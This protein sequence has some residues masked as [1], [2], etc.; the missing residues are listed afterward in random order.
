MEPDSYAELLLFVALA[1]LLGL[2][3]TIRYAL[4]SLSRARYQRLLDQ[5]ARV[6][7]IEHFFDHTS[8]YLTAAEMARGS[9]FIAVAV[10]GA[11]LVE[12][13]Q[14]AWIALLVAVVAVALTLVAGYAA[15][16]AV[17]VHEPERTAS[18][19]QWA[20]AALV[21]VFRP[22]VHVLTW[23]TRLLSRLFGHPNVPEGPMLTPEELR[24]NLAA[25]EEGGLIAEDERDMIDGIFDLEETTVWQIMV[26]RMDMVALPRTATIG[27]AV[28]LIVAGGFSRVPIYGESID[29]VIGILY[30]KDLLTLL[31]S[32]RLSDEV[33]QFVRPVFLVPESKRVDELLHE[34]QQRKT[35]IAIVID[36]YG[37]TAGLVTIEDL[38]EEIVGEIRD[39]FDREEDKIVKTEEGK[40]T[41]APAVSIDDV[42]DT[43]GTNLSSEEVD[44]IGGLAQERLGRIARIGD[45]VQDDGAVI[46][47]LSTRGRRIYR[48]SVA[49]AAPHPA[50]QESA[51]G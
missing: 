51:K 7:A 10:V 11:L 34:M 29:T 48:L 40:A 43:V 30:A 4:E 2:V 16:R 9:A 37:S 23:L 38:I 45:T 39:E 44:T 33:G 42:N 21:L 8:L 6:G 14:S 15:P 19:L 31:R 46:T 49:R 12:H 24:V 47:I 1:G 3:T 27:E 17:A 50:E 28:D 36:E 18:S 5:G 26:P 13:I 25:A 41:F 32:G 35:H 20:I 22:F